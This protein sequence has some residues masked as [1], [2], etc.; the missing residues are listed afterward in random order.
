MSRSKSSVPRLASCHT[1]AT[2]LLL[3]LCLPLPLPC[4]NNN[5]TPR[6]PYGISKSQKSDDESMGI[7]TDCLLL[8]YVMFLPPFAADSFLPMVESPLSHPWPSNGCSY[9]SSCNQYLHSPLPNYGC[10]AY[11]CICCPRRQ[12]SYHWQ[13]YPSFSFF[14]MEFKNCLYPLL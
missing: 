10:T 9:C 14:I 2:Y 3:Q 13:S 8:Y 12:H 11:S 7:W 6:T 5:T 1:W 4:A